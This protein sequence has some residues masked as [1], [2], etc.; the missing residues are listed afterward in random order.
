MDP[1]IGGH[2]GGCVVVGGVG[3]APFGALHEREDEDGPEAPGQ[4]TQQGAARVRRDVVGVV[5]E[6]CAPVRCV[7]ALSVGERKEDLAFAAFAAR[8]QI[9][10]DG[11]FRV[12]VRE[13][14]TPPSNLLRRGR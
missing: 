4:P 11:G 14:L 2:C 8:G 3:G 10:V 9:T 7:P 13:V 6:Q 1:L 12:F 5:S